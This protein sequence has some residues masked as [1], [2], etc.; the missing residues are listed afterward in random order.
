MLSKVVNAD[1]S[2]KALLQ[3]L[4]LVVMD[5]WIHSFPSHS[6]LIWMGMTMSL[7]R[8]VVVKPGRGASTKR[9]PSPDRDELT[10]CKSTPGGSLYFLVKHLETDPCSSSLSSCWP[11]I[12]RKPPLVLID[13][14]SGEK[15]L[16]SSV[17]LQLSCPV[18][19]SDT[20]PDSC[21]WSLAA[22]WGATAAGGAVLGVKR[23]WRVYP[24]QEDD[25]S[26]LL[27]QSIQLTSPGSRKGGR[28]KSCSMIMRLGCVH[29]RKGS[30]FT[31]RRKRGRGNTLLW[32]A[33]T[34][35]WPESGTR[36]KKLFPLLVFPWLANVI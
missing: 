32:S 8:M 5:H 3:P 11:V 27:A 20:P 19:I 10:C 16:T 21:L 2:F 1:I 28:P 26:L 17:I 24:G 31:S 25:A 36:R 34:S 13:I 14:S 18:L 6:C 30:Q 23:G 33:M 4:H 35:E 15:W 9:I 22:V 29:S 12:S 7:G